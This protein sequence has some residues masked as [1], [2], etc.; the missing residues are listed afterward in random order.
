MKIGPV[1]ENHTTEFRPELIDEAMLRLIDK[2]AGK[3]FFRSQ[4]MVNVNWHLLDERPN[5]TEVPE[6]HQGQQMTCTY[7]TLRSLLSNP[8][9][10]RI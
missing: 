4:I 6:G 1:S 9:S 8:F 5:W 3:Y 7:L 10:T 2:Y